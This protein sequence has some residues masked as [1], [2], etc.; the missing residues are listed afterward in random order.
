M[1]GGETPQEG[2]SVNLEEVARFDRLAATWWDL[3]GPMK[4]LHRF[5]PV[6]VDYLKQFLVNRPRRDSRPT[7]NPGRPLDGLEILD[8]GCGAG[9]LSEALA[10]L[11]AEVTGV[12]PAP[13]NIKVAQHHAEQSGLRIDYL[14]TTAEALAEKK[15]RYDVVL[16]MEVVEHVR[17]VK[18]F[19]ATAASLVRPGGVMVAA[20][21]NRTLKSYALAIV[22][23]E[24]ILRWLPRGTHDWQ[25]FVTP[26]ELRLALRS[27][28]LK[29]LDETGVVYHPLTDTWTRS[30]DMDVN[31][32]IA[33]ERK[34]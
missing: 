32:I 13:A 12:D 19:V 34:V 7:A 27:G 22:G 15:L 23:A 10:R 16:A 9:I 5:N 24:Y 6:R 1:T 17:D 2:A 8:I 20:T 21:L 26:R 33:A 3:K 11:G 31:Y 28:G 14:E 18:A 4:P 29:I 25:H 30:S